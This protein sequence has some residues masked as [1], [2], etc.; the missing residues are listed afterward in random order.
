MHALYNTDVEV[1]ADALE[2]YWVNI[3]KMPDK[4]RVTKFR[5]RGK[6]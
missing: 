6:Y 5:V 2:E 3:R 1:D 4:Q